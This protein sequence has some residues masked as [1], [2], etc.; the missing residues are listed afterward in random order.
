MNKDFLTIAMFTLV[1]VFAWIV[2]D[3]YHAVRT[4]SVTE[5]QERL[6]APLNPRFDQTT[7]NLI[8]NRA[9]QTQP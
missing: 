4:S 2:F 7:L 3:V 8:K 5:V 6:V 9:S 1:T